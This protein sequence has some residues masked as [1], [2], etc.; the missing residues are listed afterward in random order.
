MFK[1]RD[2]TELIRGAIADLAANSSIANL[3]PGSKARAVVEA[4]GSV[5]GSVAT[6]LS[7]GMVSTLLPNA[8]G[9]TLDLLADMVGLQRLNAV[10]G[11]VDEAD[12]NLKYY[13][14][15]GTFG[16]I[17]G[18]TAIV[19]PAG[20]QI[21]TGSNRGRSD[22]SMIQRAEVTLPAGASE[23]YVAADQIGQITS[24]GIAANALVRHDFIGYVDSEFQS[25]LVTNEKGIAGRPT[26]S[27]SSLRFRIANRLQSAV[28]ANAVAIRLAGLVV[29]GVND[30]RI[31]Q[32]KSGIGS[33]DVVVFGTSQAVANSVIQRVQEQ[34]DRYQAVGTRGIAVG[35]RL[36][37]LSMRI[38][39]VFKDE[40]TAS[41]RNAAANAARQAIRTFIIDIQPGGRF[42]LN[43]LVRVILNSHPMILD[44]GDPD[45][46]FDQILVWRSTASADSRFSRHL[47]QN[48]KIA[49]DEE[50]VVEYSIDNPI[51]LVEA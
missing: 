10:P 24:R 15:T 36:V 17:N 2:R 37:G 6:D 43:S 8:T 46:P 26:E 22:A 49:E 5:M 39:L 14:Q 1:T 27:D 29:P 35:P 4:V 16:D 25:L 7:V 38:R 30:I 34:I 18:G 42:V 32:N 44:V 11:K 23:A 51:E 41:E 13:V 20:T 48:I 40:A 45:D 9:P 31:I 47:R 19:V 12:G 3:S 28:A 33:F 50:L 21:R